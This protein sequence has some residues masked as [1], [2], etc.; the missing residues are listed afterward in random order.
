MNDLI[1]H[2]TASTPVPVTICPPKKPRKPRVRK[3]AQGWSDLT[4]TELRAACDSRGVK[5]TT[6]HTKQELIAM[7]KTGVYVR[8]AAYDRAA[9]KRKAKG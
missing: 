8:P 1:L 2:P 6:K 7:A 4:V 5:H 3:P 9:A